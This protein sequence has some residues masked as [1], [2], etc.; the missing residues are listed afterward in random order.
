MASSTVIDTGASIKK[1]FDWK[2]YIVK[3]WFFYLILIPV[4]AYY[5]IF[6]YVPMYGIII[7]FK[8]Y[9]PNLGVWRSPW[10]KNNGFEH[11]IDYFGSIFFM[12][13]FGNTLKISV[14][15]LVFGFPAPIILALML[16]EVKTTSIKRTVQTISY[17]PHF[18]SIVI[19]AG[20]VHDFLNFDGMLTTIM[21]VLFGAEKK[22][23][24]NDVR[25]YRSIYVISGI[26]QTVGWGA[27][28]Y[29]ASLS[30][31]DT[32]LYDAAEIDGCG[33]LRKMWHV[34]I[35]GIIPT[36][37][38]L[39]ILRIGAMLNVGHEKTLLLYNPN[40]FEVSDVI[41]TYVYRKAFGIGQTS[42]SGN[43]AF[44]ATVNLVNS[45]VN[46]ILLTSANFLSRRYSETSLW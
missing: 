8:R 23:W 39:L 10:A 15:S 35:P 25:A 32:Q 3:N 16:N 40:T 18:I 36:I 12:R 24:L 28:I 46:L 22:V 4:M 13:T 45:V 37:M 38:I 26:W 29:L 44:S 21:N 14:L 30:N 42:S 19:I 41:M 34:T 7:A 20:M 11:F 1:P 43:F 17:L 31:I 2:E 6:K 5:I 33:I 27:I 9:R